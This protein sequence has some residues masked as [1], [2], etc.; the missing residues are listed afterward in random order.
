MK[1]KI[2]PESYSCS[3]IGLSEF[4]TMEKT[5]LWINLIINLGPVSPFRYSIICYTD[6]RIILLNPVLCVTMVI[7][8]IELARIQPNVLW[9]I[10]FLKYEIRCIKNVR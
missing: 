10:V 6:Y 1:L 7:D 9:N 2:Y 4:Q 3:K 5:L 8:N